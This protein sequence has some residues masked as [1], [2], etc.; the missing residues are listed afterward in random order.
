MVNIHALMK[1][2]VIAETDMN[3]GVCKLMARML[4]KGT[5]TRTADQIAETMESAGGA[6]SYIAGNNSFDIAAES[7]SED[8]DRTLDVLADVLQNPTFPDT[9]LARERTVQIAEF[10]QE[11]DQIL[12]QGQQV[13]REAIFTQHPYRLNVL[14]KPETVAKLT[15]ADLV[16]FH[17]RFVVPN[18]MVLT[19]FG[20]VKADDV[21][22]KIEAR[23]S[24]MKSVKIEF[25]RS[26]PETLAAD[27]RK[28]EIV[29]KQQAV[30]LIG[31]SGVDMFSKD[32]FAME[33]L[34]EAYSGLGSR[35]FQRIRDELG[36]CY[37]VG[38]YQ[39]VGLDPGY[40]AFY[41]GT[42]PQNV[43]QCEKEIFAELE[44]LKADGLSDE[45]LTRAKAGVIG[46][47]RVRMQDNSELGMMVGLDELT[48]L[49]YDFF[50]TADD[51]YQAVT[52]DDIKRVAN[53]YF[54]GK[55]HAVVIVTPSEEKE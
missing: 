19:V 6:I 35:V 16:D 5:T 30:L 32:R 4:L 45:E 21:R 29:P 38:A 34:S 41:V 46:Q 2:G 47:R 14:G 25:P 22:Q 24:G 36:L 12:R 52:L 8:L 10:K 53:Q 37:Y 3:N 44:K 31:Y 55:P 26:G 15:R 39:L 43:G 23:C 20:N 11:Q 48:G 33:L 28:I 13:L 7:L 51:K 42:T 50:K 18:N 17:R 40:F 9:L 54:S 1:G 49:G 27:T